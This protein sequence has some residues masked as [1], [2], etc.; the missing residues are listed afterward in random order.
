MLGGLS[1]PS[2]KRVAA[3]PQVAVASR[4]RYGHW[5][6]GA[7]TQALTAV[8]PA[9]LPRVAR[10]H[11]TAGGLQRA[12]GR[13]R[14][15]RRARRLGSEG[16]PSATP[17]HDVPAG[18]PA[19]VRV[20]G[21]LGTGQRRRCRRT[22][23]VARHVRRAHYSENV[24]AS[25]VRRPARAVST[26]SGSRSTRAAVADFTRRGNPRPGCSAAGR[27]AAI[28]EVLGLITVLLG[29]AVLIALL[30][31]TNTLGVV[32]RRADPRNRPAAGGRHDPVPVAAHGP[33]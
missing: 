4:P 17:C 26:R 5:R 15:H 3:L 18:R 7:A 6:D 31:I 12:R 2:R 33:R 1:P 24:D 13:W 23:S 20:V 9:T 8:D 16:W 25:R 21:V 28:E 19:A 14:R 10:L 32:H 11:F 22:T 30:G 27:A 29:F